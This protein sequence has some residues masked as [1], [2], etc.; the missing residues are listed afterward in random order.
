MATRRLSPEQARAQHLRV[1]YR[2]VPEQYDDMLLAQG[3]VCA[4]CGRKPTTRRLA[5][6]HDHRCCPGPKSCGR[7]V[8]G[9]LDAACN[10]NLG[11]YLDSPAVLRTAAAEA[12]AHPPFNSDMTP[13]RG[14][15]ALFRRAADYVERRSLDAEPVETGCVGSA[16]IDLDEAFFAEVFG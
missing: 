12:E 2:M 9:L 10:T 3:G 15:P 5:V 4:I 14:D 1:F 16:S 6:D 11:K 13:F 8:R 7:C